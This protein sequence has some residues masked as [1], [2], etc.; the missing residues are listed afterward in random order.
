MSLYKI[1]V[2]KEK[3]NVKL[4]MSSSSNSSR[5]NRCH[6]N[7]QEYDERELSLNDS[8]ENQVHIKFLLP[9]TTTGSVIG[10]GGERI[11]SLQKETNTKMKMSKAGVN[12]F[13]F[14]LFQMNKNVNR[15]IFLALKNVFVLL[16]EK[17][18]MFYLFMNFYPI[19]S[20]K[21]FQVIFF[22]HVK[23]N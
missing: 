22:V 21:I 13:V 23:L 3:L 14:S 11:A 20:K 16:L 10:K 7:R 1:N 18:S 4:S 5:H 2:R 6:S 17:L 15:I 9:G 8:N 19:K 12:F